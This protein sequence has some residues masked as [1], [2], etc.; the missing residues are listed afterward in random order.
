[1]QLSIVGPRE[2]TRL[3]RELGLRARVV[4]I[5]FFPFGPVFESNREQIRRVEEL[6]DAHHLTLG[7]TDLT[8]AYL[9]E[10]ERDDV[11]SAAG[12]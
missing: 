5:N 12:S 7:G 8:V 10:I 2:T 6:S 9:L 4:D 3:L 11:S 1:M